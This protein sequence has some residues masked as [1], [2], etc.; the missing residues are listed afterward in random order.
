MR[1]RGRRRAEEK[2]RVYDKGEDGKVGKRK[3]KRRRGRRTGVNGG[4]VK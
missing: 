4:K 2:G 3:E 1:N